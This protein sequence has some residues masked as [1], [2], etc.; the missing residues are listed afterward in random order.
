MKKPLACALAIGLSSGLAAQT[1]QYV[2]VQKQQNYFQDSNS[3]VQ[4][5]TT[6]PFQ[7]QVNVTGSGLT[8]GNPT[9]SFIPPG[10]SSTNLSFDSNNGSLRYKTSYSDQASMD[11]AFA[12]GTYSVTV[13][14]TTGSM[15]LT[16]DKYPTAPQVSLTG[17]L[18][19]ITSNGTLAVNVNDSS[20]TLATS[21]YSDFQTYINNSTL[22]SGVVGF[23]FE[24]AINGQGLSFED[25][26]ISFSGT[27]F[28]NDSYNLNPASL[29]VGQT[30]D[31]NVTFAA[32]VGQDTSS[33]SGLTGSP[34]GVAIYSTQTSFQIQAVPEPRLY[35][36]FAG[37]LALAVVA[38]G[39][40][41][42]EAAT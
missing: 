11:T 16:G 14:S 21:T 41:R 24:F 8:S 39:R 17:A 13:D 3:T 35:A 22:P 4:L 20:I 25:K 37:M 30:Y 26:S 40:W 33:Y 12:N 2:I 32:I 34:T 27:Q 5:Q 7:F 18:N 10:G 1:L 31:V 36:L 6:N 15:D 29:T 38:C 23:Y 9:G 42:R 19:S 28:A